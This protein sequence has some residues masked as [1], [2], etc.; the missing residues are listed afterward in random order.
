MKVKIGDYVYSI[1]DLNKNQRDEYWSMIPQ[2]ITS[3]ILYSNRALTD[4]NYMPF[5]LTDTNTNELNNYSNQY[6]TRE[7][8]IKIFKKRKIDYAKE[9]DNYI[10]EIIDESDYIKN[11]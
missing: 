4:K 11:K 7:E 2:K 9:I 1:E 6:I 10:K 8:L 5:I 3:I